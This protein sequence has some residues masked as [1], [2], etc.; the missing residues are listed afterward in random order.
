FFYAM[1]YPGESN[2][3]KLVSK[4]KEEQNNYLENAETEWVIIDGPPGIGCPV[5]A[6]ISGVNM[7]VIV[8][9][10]T[11]SGFHDLERLIKLL[12]T[13]K[14]KM[15]VIINKYEM[16]LTKSE[17]IENYLYE[18]NILYLGYLSYNYA[19]VRALQNKKTIVDY[20][21]VLGEQITEIWKLLQK[22]IEE[23]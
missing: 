19:A 9:E 14:V 16:N 23:N 13:F 6:S 11:N 20:S 5:N 1:L 2:S 21:P 8:T 17:K 7:A 18:N 4:I 15:A 22:T 12:N 3:G 10:P